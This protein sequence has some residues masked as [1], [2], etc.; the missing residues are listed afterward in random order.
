MDSEQRFDRP[1]L[2]VIGLTSPCHKQNSHQTCV[3]QKQILARACGACGLAVI[4]D[5]LAAS[6]HFVV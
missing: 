1:L 2:K 5:D 4:N 6:E 3:G